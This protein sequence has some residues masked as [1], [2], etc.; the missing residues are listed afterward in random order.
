M[1]ADG[2]HI[3]YQPR[4]RLQLAASPE[5]TFVQRRCL[6]Q[7]QIAVLLAG[8]LIADPDKIA[9]PSCLMHGVFSFD[10]LRFDSSSTDLRGG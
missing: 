5:D 2:S 4:Q 7:E 8:K 6:S 9:L 3:N 10:S 1:A